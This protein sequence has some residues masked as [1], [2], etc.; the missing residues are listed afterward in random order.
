MNARE[1]IR[2]NIEF[3]FANIVRPYL[4]DLSEADLMVRPAP[5]ANHIKWQLGHLI[6]SDNGIVNSVCPGV[7]PPLPAGFDKQHDKAAA[8]SDNP[9]D[10]R[11]KEEYLKLAEG[12][13]DAAIKALM[14]LS[15]ADL[16][17]KCPPPFDHF[18]KSWGDMFLLLGTHWVMHGGQWAVIRR[19][20]GRA[21][22][23]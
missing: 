4:Q 9:A 20:L 2:L 22:L 14:S 12:Q 13:R 18:M 3:S 15:D 8:A 5:G 11:S 6:Q 10:F 21:P 7:M 1:A 19:Q 17:K 16:D 23:F